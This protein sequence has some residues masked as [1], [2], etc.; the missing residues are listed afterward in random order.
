[1]KRETKEEQDVNLI[2]PVTIV[3]N[4]LYSTI[5]TA[6]CHTQVKAIRRTI[7][8]RRSTSST[9]TVHRRMDEN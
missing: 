2:D 9:V 1:M 8:G 6:N 5:E 4:L 3:S 7:F